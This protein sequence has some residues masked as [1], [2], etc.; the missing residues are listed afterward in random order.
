MHIRTERIYSENQS[1]GQRILVDRVWPRGVSKSEAH[2]DHWLKEVG[3][4]QA[5]RKWFNHDA[6]KFETFKSKYQQ[7]LKENQAQK[8]AFDQLKA[9]VNDSDDDVI[10]L[11]GA[12]DTKH[13]QAIVLKD[14]L[15]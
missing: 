13:N 3:P 4:S 2:L 14:L 10:L 8:E 15:S 5:L 6:E 7:E 11:Y 1:K 12:K 9:I